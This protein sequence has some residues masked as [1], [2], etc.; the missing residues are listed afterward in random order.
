M[1]SFKGSNMLFFSFVCHFS[2]ILYS[3][4]GAAG[5]SRAARSSWDWDPEKGH[6]LGPFNDSLQWPHWNVI[7]SV[8]RTCNAFWPF[9]DCY[10]LGFVFAQ[11]FFF[12]L[13][14]KAALYDDIWTCFSANKEPLFHSRLGSPASLFLST[15][16]PR[17]QSK[18]T[19]TE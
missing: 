18:K 4:S 6:L 1:F 15:P 16:V 17:S 7:C 9:E 11:F 14:P 5:M 2:R 13:L 10:L 3:S 12:F 19:M 8:M